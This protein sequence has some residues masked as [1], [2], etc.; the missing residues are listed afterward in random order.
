VMHML[1]TSTL[2]L[3]FTLIGIQSTNAFTRDA[4]A[5]GVGKSEY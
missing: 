2:D 1:F 5:Q 4:I 3:D